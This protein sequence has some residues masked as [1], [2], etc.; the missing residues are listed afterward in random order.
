M[1]WKDHCVIA[2]TETISIWHD[3]QSPDNAKKFRSHRRGHAADIIF[4]FVVE[5]LG[6]RI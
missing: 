5:V 1:W 6:N 2:S 3:V 4:L